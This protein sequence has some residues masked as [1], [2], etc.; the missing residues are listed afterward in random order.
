MYRST[1]VNIRMI[2]LNLMVLWWILF[3]SIEWYVYNFLICSVIHLFQC[4]V[5]VWFHVEGM[6]FVGGRVWVSIVSLPENSYKECSGSPQIVRWKY[7]SFTSDKLR[8]DAI[9]LILVRSASIAPSRARCTQAS[10][11]HRIFQLSEWLKILC[12]KECTELKNSDNQR[13]MWSRKECRAESLEILEF[14]T[15][16]KPSSGEINT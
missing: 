14:A 13:L 12:C 8:R 2:W 15:K 5:Y 7:L 11:G 3:T 9:A 4:C 6:K 10:W 16:K 1:W